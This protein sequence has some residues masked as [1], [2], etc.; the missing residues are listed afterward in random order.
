M[1]KYCIII[2]NYNHHQQIHEVVRTLA[3]FNL[4][5]FMVNDASSDKTRDVLE[6]LEQDTPL[7]TLV[8]HQTNQGKGGAVQTGLNTA[9]AQG[10]THALQ[11]DAD[12]QH[13]LADIAP[14]LALSQNNPKAVIS[15]APVFDDSIPKHRFISRYI[16]H[17]WVTIETLSFALKDTMCGFRVYPLAPYDS[18]QRRVPLGKRMDFDIE[19][20]VRL[21]WQNTPVIFRP[22]KVTYPEDGASHFK[23]FKDN[24]LISWMHTRLFFGMLRRIPSLLG[25]KFQS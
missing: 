8:H 20:L 22:T 6:A 15:G 24:L 1:T 19:I 16:T 17:F 2:P 14:M 5:I 4:P 23:L 18:L 7:L 12:G 25:R 21:Y 10:F 11:I 9:Y 13:N 3:P